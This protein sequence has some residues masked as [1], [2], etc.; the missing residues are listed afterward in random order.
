MAMPYIE[1]KGIHVATLL[2]AMT[3]AACQSQQSWVK[4]NSDETLLISRAVWQDFEE[5]KLKLG[6]GT[7]VFVVTDNG[8]ASAY[9]YCPTGRCHPGDFPARALQW[10]KD[11]D[12][13]CV[14]FAFGSMIQVDYEIAD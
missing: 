6:S 5:Y 14:A 8:L 1:R 7:G 9:S 10:C 11:A 4:V 13:G 12:V 3:F 2:G